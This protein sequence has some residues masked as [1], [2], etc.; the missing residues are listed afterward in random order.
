MLKKINRLKNPISLQSIINWCVWAYVA[1]YHALKKEIEKSNGRVVSPKVLDIERGKKNIAAYFGERRANQWVTLAKKT[2][3]ESD[4]VINQTIDMLIADKQKAQPKFWSTFDVRKDGKWF[5]YSMLAIELSDFNYYIPTAIRRMKK[6]DQPDVMLI[7]QPNAQTAVMSEKDNIDFTYVARA[8]RIQELKMMCDNKSR[9]TVRELSV[10][11]NVNNWPKNEA[12]WYLHE[13]EFLN[14]LYCG[15]ESAPNAHGTQIPF[16]K[17]CKLVKTVM[18]NS[19]HRD[20][21]RSCDRGICAGD[22]CPFFRLYMPMC[23][24]V[25]GTPASQAV[26]QLENSCINMMA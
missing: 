4:A 18:G 11:G 3:E 2:K 9:F 21:Y 23:T 15:A 6:R 22:K 8:L 24:Q 17:M 5:E 12:Y 16:E 7:R 26:V 20:F 19:F 13:K 25:R 14:Q 10:Q 1:E